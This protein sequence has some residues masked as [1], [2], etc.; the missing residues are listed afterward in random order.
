MLYYEFVPCCARLLVFICTLHIT[1]ILM[2]GFCLHSKAEVY[3]VDFDAERAAREQQQHEKLQLLD[4]MRQCQTHNKQ[5]E[6]QIALLVMQL[7]HPPPGASSGGWRNGSDTSEPEG[8][9]PSASMVRKA[10]PLHVKPAMFVE[11]WCLCL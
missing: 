2:M 6:R 1:Y 11:L 4:D 9:R 5:L 3:K 8:R 10:P 7:R